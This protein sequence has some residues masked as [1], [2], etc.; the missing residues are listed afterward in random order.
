M[1]N[2]EWIRS[3]DRKAMSDFLCQDVPCVYCAESLKNGNAL[4]CDSNCSYGVLQWLQEEQ[5]ASKQ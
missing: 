4:G 5:D 1:T 3:L 2:F